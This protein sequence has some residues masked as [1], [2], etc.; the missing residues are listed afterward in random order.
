VS[1]TH[2]SFKVD[3]VVE[4]FRHDMTDQRM[5]VKSIRLDGMG[6]QWLQIVDDVTGVGR[7]EWRFDMLKKIEETPGDLLLSTSVVASP[8]DLA[9]MEGWRVGSGQGEPSNPDPAKVIEDVRWLIEHET[10]YAFDIDWRDDLTKLLHETQPQD[11]SKE[12][13]RGEFITALEALRSSATFHG[14]LWEDIGL[15]ID[16]IRSLPPTS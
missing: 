7:G 15:A 5:R 1:I 6:N 16:T 13:G 10:I 3:D 4:T 11:V 12:P 8:E 2:G 14:S 9:Y